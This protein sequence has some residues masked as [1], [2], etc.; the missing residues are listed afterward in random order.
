MK[1]PSTSIKNAKFSSNLLTATFGFSIGFFVYMLIEKIYKTFFSES[2]THW[3]MGLIA[4]L[5]FV[6]LFFFDK[7]RL[8]ILF[9]AFVGGLF[10]T[11]AELFTGILVNI[12]YRLGIWDYQQMLLNY[13]GQICVAFSTI[14]CV[15]SLIIILVNR[16]LSVFVEGQLDKSRKYH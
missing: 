5:A 7:L 11:A 8:H 15:A 9:K 6:F 16:S 14:W 1:Q 12:K 3:S 2:Q 13:R 4:G 10:I